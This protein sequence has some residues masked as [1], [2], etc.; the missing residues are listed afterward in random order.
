MN[1]SPIRIIVADSQPDFRESIVKSF[2]AQKDFCIVGVGS[3]GYDA[4]S[5]VRETRPDV[6]LVEFDLPVLDGLKIA[7]ALMFHSPATQMLLLLR[8]CDDGHILRMVSV[9]SY[10]CVLESCPH[11]EICS[12]VRLVHRGEGYITNKIAVHVA[13]LLADHLYGGRRRPSVPLGVNKTAFNIIGLLGQGRT[14]R[15]IATALNLSEGT[16]RN[17]ISHL[18]QKLGFEQRTQLAVYAC[19]NG[20]T[21]MMQSLPGENTGGDKSSAKP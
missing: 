11:D 3:D 9:G 1:T 10:N 7:A 12:A 16:V 8:N 14:T 15:E 6:A 19:S 5:L 13:S 2:S 21:M 4:L 17:H 18:L 20:I